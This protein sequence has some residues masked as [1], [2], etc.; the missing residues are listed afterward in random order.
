M[1]STT[2]IHTII[3]AILSWVITVWVVVIAL[4]ILAFIFYQGNPVC[5]GLIGGKPWACTFREYLREDLAMAI[6]GMVW[7]PFLSICLYPFSWVAIDSVSAYR[8]SHKKTIFPEM[9]KKFFRLGFS[10][11]VSLIVSFIIITFY[12]SYLI[13]TLHLIE[14]WIFSLLIFLIWPLSYYWIYRLI[15]NKVEKIK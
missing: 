11:I 15:T 2:P 3:K 12:N 9:R 5:E 1:K 10:F 7:L 6:I 13:D 8:A 14:G 4:L